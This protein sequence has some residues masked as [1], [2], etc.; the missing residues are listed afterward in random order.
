[1]KKRTEF[2]IERKSP[3]A[4]A[5][6]LFMAASLA[7]RALWAEAAAPEGD[8]FIT[9]VCLPMLSAA[10]F[11]ACVLLWGEK[12]LWT[13]FF[14]ALLGVLFFILKA[15]SFSSKIQTVL[16]VL[17]YL[18]VAAFFGLTV[19]G[20]IPT[21]KPLI[22]LFA[23]PMAFHIFVEDLILHRQVYTAVNWLQEFS[24]LCIMAGL[25]CLSI[26]MRERGTAKV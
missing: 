19:F 20:L 13:S 3:W 11:A 17:L 8:A 9:L 26:G 5:A 16:C 1:M 7:L 6:V 15:L 4:I 23:L 2:Y 24:V 25:L 12:A 18:L 10:L 14:P 22:P 21:K